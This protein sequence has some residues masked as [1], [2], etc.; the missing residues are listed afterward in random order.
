MNHGLNFQFSQTRL[1]TSV[2]KTKESGG[3]GG[4]LRLFCIIIEVIV[5]FWH[6]KILQAIIIISCSA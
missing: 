5:K 3:K 4:N 1:M 2:L 6:I